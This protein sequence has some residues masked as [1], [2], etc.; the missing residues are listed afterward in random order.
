MLALDEEPLS[1]A[2][3]NAVSIKGR[4]VAADERE[5]G[6]RALLNLGHTF[7]HAIEVETG[8]G[9]AIKHG[10]AVAAGCALAFRLS[11]AL[12]L[13]PAKDAGR[14]ATAIAAAGL[15]SRL[16]DLGG[17]KWSAKALVGHMAQDKKSVGGALNLVLTR[18]IGEAFVAKDIDPARLE[19]F[20]V[21]EGAAP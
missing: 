21:A 5:A 16:A 20:L 6:P 10:E 14:A 18:R 4:I 15:P 8:Y 9:E 3:G 11:V 1:H 12:G 19:A 17:G 2:V 7:G 13:C